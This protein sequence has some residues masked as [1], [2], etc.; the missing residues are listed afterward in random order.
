MSDQPEAADEAAASDTL[1]E[2]LTGYIALRD[3]KKEIVEQQRVVVKQ[4]D[5]AME[6]I[7]NYLKGLLKTQGLQSV[8]SKTGV[9][10][11]RRTRSATIGDK[12]AFRE[13]VISTEDFDLVDF[14]ANVDA[15]EGY[16]NENEGRTPPGVNWSVFENVSVNRK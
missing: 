5:D 10:F 11:I 16:I 8:A 4:Y 2:M 15:V 12:S 13:H 3:K 7:E 6:E 14:R 1:E 9:A